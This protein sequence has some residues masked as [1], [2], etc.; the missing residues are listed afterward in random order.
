[1]TDIH[2]DLIAIGAGSGGLSVAQRAASYGAKTAVI[3]RDSRL[4]GT[5][6][7]RG[8][9]PKKIMW[10]GAQSLESIHKAGGYSI[11]VSLQGADW[12]ALVAKR[13]ANISGINNWYT[14]YL[15][16]ASVDVLYG[17][18]KFDGP[19]RLLVGDQ[20]YT[21]DHIVIA[22]GG[23]PTVPDIPGAE[24]G[25]TSDGF[26]ELTER[27]ARVAVVGAG[28]IAVELAGV[29]RGFG[30]ETDL[31]IRRNFPLR[32]FDPLI[33]RTAL[34]T[35]Q[36]QG[37]NVR[38]GCTPTALSQSS[39]GLMVETA[40][41]SVGPYDT[42]IWAIGRYPL[43]ASL[44]LDTA[45]VST[46]AQGYVPTDEYQNTDVAGVYAIGDVTGQAQLTPVAIAAGRRLGDRL[47]GGKADA[48]LDYSNIPT[49]V[50]THP[51]IGVVGMTE[52][53]AREAFGSDNVTVYQTQFAPMVDTFEDHPHPTAMKLV[54]QGA[55]EK[56]VGI[57]MMGTGV[58]EMLQGFAV[59]LKMG[60]T[61]AD[62]DNTV[63]IHPT[64]SEELVTLKPEHIVSS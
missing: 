30:A 6:V 32:S 36:A 49:V 61:K 12:G 57:H 54:T 38:T 45:G 33:Q 17:D 43:S 55:D 7:N 10:Y 35:M 8:C 51:P 5:C 20:A 9:V 31:L 53:E 63:A 37:V 13:E 16:E 29:L 1:M 59:A 24:L 14:G 26:F 15:S 23:A 48:H 60:A 42:V 18:A 44:A 21:A 39:T 58:D 2:Y 28:Y 11:D 41:G 46:D 4:G 50:F 3:E 22:P 52:P 62:F 56:V 27:P 34:A 19:H 64:S 47:F 40:D 25:I